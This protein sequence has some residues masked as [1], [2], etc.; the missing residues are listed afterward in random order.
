MGKGI[1]WARRQ[2]G[3]GDR[4]GKEIEWAN[5]QNGQGDRMG[6]EIEWAKGQNGQR[7]A[8]TVDNIWRE[9]NFFKKAHKKWNIETSQNSASCQ[10]RVF[11]WCIY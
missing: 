10:S 4:M 9:L 7:D 2:N 6:K 11:F 1:E 8:Y 3:Q 5:R